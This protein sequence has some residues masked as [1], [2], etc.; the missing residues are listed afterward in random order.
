MSGTD[1]VQTSQRGAWRLAGLVSAVVIFGGGPGC[2]SNDE[3]EPSNPPQFDAP[4]ISC[5]DS[6]QV[7]GRVVGSVSVEVTDPERD[8]VI[9][10]EG[11]EGTFDGVAIRLTDEDG[12]QRFEWTPSDE[13]R[14]V[15][16]GTHEL[17]VQAR[18]DDGNEARLDREI[19]KDGA[20]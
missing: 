7:D 8:L 14:F 10:E 19:D 13:Q 20:S 16:A 1:F 4:E 6:Q 18:D 17:I 11:L 9:P 15:C 5:E 2:G 12:D 3:P